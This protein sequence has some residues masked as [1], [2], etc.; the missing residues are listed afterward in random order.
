MY[1]IRI[2]KYIVCVCRGQSGKGNHRGVKQE[3]RETIEE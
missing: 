2:Y 3:A 1:V